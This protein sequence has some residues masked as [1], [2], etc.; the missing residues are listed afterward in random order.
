[1]VN[2]LRPLVALVAV[3][4]LTALAGPS[5]AEGDLGGPPPVTPPA[6]T[7]GPPEQPAKT[8][9]AAGCSLVAGP[10]YIGASCGSA[11]NRDGRTVKEILGDDPVPDCWQEPM[12]QKELDALGYEN[13]AGP[14]GW[15]WVWER[16]LTGID[17]KTK[18]LQ[19][20]GIQISIEP[21]KWPNGTAFTTL[22]HNQQELVELRG[23]DQMI[24][25]PVAIVSPAYRP[26]VGQV[27]WFRDGTPDS[28]TDFTVDVGRVALHA[29]IVSIEVH[30]LGWGKGDEFTCAGKGVRAGAGATV[31]DHPQ[32]HYKYEHSS[33]T[34]EDRSYPVTV[35]AIWQVDLTVQGGA[36]TVFATFEKSQ[37]TALPV[38]EIQTVVVP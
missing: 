1:V 16:C 14:D 31:A 25:P 38:T 17:K 30:P 18:R 9:S 5:Y 15:T 6:T 27:V 37:V 33:A 13:Q 20:G 24:P 35:V 19:D 32:C 29:H 21:K 12:T 26:R 7:A 4:V 36:S 8:G 11:K 22:T 23:G 34:Q 28:E 2:R 10:K 3:G